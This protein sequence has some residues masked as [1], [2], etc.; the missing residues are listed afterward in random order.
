[1]STSRL[2]GVIRDDL[3]EMAARVGEAVGSLRGA[4]VLVTGAAGFLPSY[5][6][7]LLAHLNDESDDPCRVLCVDNLSTGTAARLAH[8][9]GRDDVV[10]VNADVAAGVAVDERV[11]FIFHGA[12]IASPVWYRRFPLETIDVNVSGTRHLLEMARAHPTR[13]FV[14][15]SSSEVYGDPPPEE[16]PTPETYWGHVSCTGPRA[17]YDESKRLAE[18]LAFTYHRLHDIPV[19][20]IRPFNV[21]GPRLR[22]DDGRVIPD[23]LRAAL[24]GEPIVLHSD[25]NVTRSFCYLA[26]FIVAALLLMVDDVAGEAFNVG[27]DEEV[28]IADAARLVD[29]VAGGT[30]GVRFETSDDPDYL[31]DNPNRRCPDLTKTKAAI[32]WVPKV[33]LRTG[34]ERTLRHYRESDDR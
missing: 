27:N 10:V 22:L 18:T 24:V 19:K 16:I 14:L 8:L 11:D 13:S 2:G 15:L 1:M 34:I 17:C 21:Y 32:T 29:D 6:V 31:T 30:S 7:D 33:D 20:V 3:A 28:T 5:L 4:T 26:D 25:G 12:S 9:E 23:L